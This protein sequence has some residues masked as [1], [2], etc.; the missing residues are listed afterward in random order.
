[1]LQR[2]PSRPLPPT[3]WATL[4]GMSLL[5]NKNNSNVLSSQLGGYRMDALRATDLK[6]S[7]HYK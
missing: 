2:A 4:Y 7:C 6:I 1:M 5:L 3:I